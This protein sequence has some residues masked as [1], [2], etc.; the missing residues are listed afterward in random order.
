MSTKTVAKPIVA[1]DQ[2]Y[3]APVLPPEHPTAALFLD[4]SGVIKTDRFF[5]I[6]VLKA[7]DCPTLTRALRRHRQVLECIEELHWSHFD[8][9]R[10]LRD[11][12]FELAVAAIDTFFELD[13]VSFCCLLADRQ[14]GDLIRSYR[15]P[16]HAYEGIARKVLGA[17]IG[18]REVVSVFADHADTPPHVRFE[19]TVR[20]AVNE[21][22]DRL[23]IATMMRGHSHA[24]DALQLADVLL[25][26]AMFDFRQGAAK[27]GLDG[28]SQKGR[29]SAHLLAHCD[30]P[31]FRPKGRKLVGKFEVE[32]S[33]WRPPR[34]RRRGGDPT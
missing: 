10:S 5:G 19:E 16:H 9:A 6:G 17:A 32:L 34:R 22:K 27:G 4:E 8:K 29:L 31:S 28:E 20:S 33:R 7:V 23:A 12:S 26:A 1:T 14:E 24:I 2:V 18:E 11:R 21:D 15:S 13:G 25:G 30:V 3:A